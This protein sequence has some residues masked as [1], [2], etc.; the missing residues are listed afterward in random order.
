MGGG[1]HITPGGRHA[2]HVLTLTI[3]VGTAM[4]STQRFLTG[5]K[6]GGGGGG[7]FSGSR[8]GIL[9]L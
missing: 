6:G 3:A 7:G 8:R 4:L 2:S 5:G 9:Y 1:P